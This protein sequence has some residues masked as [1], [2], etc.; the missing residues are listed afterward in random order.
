VTSFWPNNSMQRMGASRSGHWQLE[1]LRR[2]APTADADRYCD[3]RLCAQMR[4][5][6]QC[7]SAVC[8]VIRILGRPAGAALLPRWEALLTMDRWHPGGCR[9]NN[10]KGTLPLGTSIRT[11]ARIRAVWLIST[12]PLHRRYA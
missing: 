6:K 5:H 3:T 4:T 12:K 10:R 11:R 1:R 7:E 8:F 9:E 2:L